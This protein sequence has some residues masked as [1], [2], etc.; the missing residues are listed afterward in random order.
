MM[1]PPKIFLPVFSAFEKACQAAP[2]SA[3]TGGQDRYGNAAARGF[4]AIF[5]F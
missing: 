1:P 3:P 4:A 2:M 5:P